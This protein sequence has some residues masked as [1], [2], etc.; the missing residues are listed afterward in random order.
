MADRLVDRAS[1]T[2]PSDP[3]SIAASADEATIAR[4]ISRLAALGID[5]FRSPAQ[6][7][8]QGGVD[9][10][11]GGADGQLPHRRRAMKRATSQLHG[12]EEDVQGRHGGDN[13]AS[14][15]AKR[16]DTGHE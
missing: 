7:N 4:T 10:D 15:A 8:D 2:A 9:D 14:Q 6:K 1:G 5:S 11:H 12:C 3:N 16:G 13:G